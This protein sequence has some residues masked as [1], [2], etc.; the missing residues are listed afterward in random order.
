MDENFKIHLSMMKILEAGLTSAAVLIS[1]GAVLG[2][3]NPFQTLI[4][5]LIESTVFVANAFLGY[6]VL[7]TL[8]VGGAIFIHAFGAY[9]GITVA[10]VLRRKNYSLSEK[11]EESVYHSDLFAMVSK[12][13]SFT[14]IYLKM[15]PDVC[16]DYFLLSSDWNCILVDILAKFQCHPCPQWCIPQS[17]HE[18]LP[19]STGIHHFHLHF[20]HSSRKVSL[21][22]SILE[23]IFIYD[24]SG[25]KLDMVD[26]QN[27]TLSGGVAVGAI[28]DLMIQPYGAFLA[29]TFTGL[30]SCWGY[31]MAQPFLSRKFGLHDTCGVNNLHGMPGLIS[32]VLSIL[33]CYLAS[34]EGYGPSFYLLFPLAAPKEG[35]ASLRDLQTKLTDI[36]AGANRT[37]ETQALMQLSALAITMGVAVLSGWATGILLNIPSVFHIL[38]EHEYFDGTSTYL[39]LTFS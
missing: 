39:F 37:M 18:H 20:L 9:F 14:Q 36:E 29:G 4:M 8:D 30:V 25:R 17:H 28:A 10:L 16:K 15:F 27:A 24:F 3:L 38:G 22:F 33:F 5:A 23:Q 34:E 21:S 35:S 26:I 2:K 32:G 6:K 7:G 11:L 12:S 1:F 13:Y 31:R 19:F